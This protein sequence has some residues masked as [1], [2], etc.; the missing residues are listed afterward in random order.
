MCIISVHLLED[1]CSHLRTN[2]PI[3]SNWR[4]GW[5]SEPRGQGLKVHEEWTNNNF[6]TKRSVFYWRLSKHI[7]GIHSFSLQHDRGVGLPGLSLCCQEKNSR[8]HLTPDT[9]GDNSR[10]EDR[11]WEARSFLLFCESSPLPSSLGSFII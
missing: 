10:T 6:H 11:N 5:Q 2:S 8:E 9:R 7:L 3:D 4:L 1:R